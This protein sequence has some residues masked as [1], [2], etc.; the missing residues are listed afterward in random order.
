[1]SDSD[2]LWRLEQ[3]VEALEAWQRQV[4]GPREVTAPEPKGG[5][6]EPDLSAEGDSLA[7]RIKRSGLVLGED[8]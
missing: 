2:D 1:M 3:R 6:D 7:A 5:E 8:G 4:I